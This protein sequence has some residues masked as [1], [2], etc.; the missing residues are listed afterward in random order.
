MAWL[1][2]VCIGLVSAAGWL[3][4]Q[5]PATAAGGAGPAIPSHSW[6]VGGVAIFEPLLGEKFNL[7]EKFFLCLNVVIALAGL[8]YALML[9]GQVKNAPQGHQADAGDRPR[10]PRRGQCLPLP[11]VPRR[12]RA[13]RADHRP[14]VLRRQCFAPAR[15]VLVGRALAFFFG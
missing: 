3:V 11:A 5:E 10:H 2:F 6:I 8:G 7:Y 12:G 14:A 9:V 1:A 15:G 13:D 4:A